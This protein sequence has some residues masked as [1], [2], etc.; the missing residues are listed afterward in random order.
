MRY[1]AIASL[2]LVSTFAAQAVRADDNDPYIRSGGYLGVGATYGV[3]FM[4]GTFKDAFSPLDGDVSNTWG[5]HATGGYRFGK[6]ISTEVE[7]EWMKAFNAR[8]S[9]IAVTALETQTATLNLKIHAPYK[10]F[11]PYFLVGAGATWVTQDKHFF[12]PLDVT[13]PSFSAR[14][15]AGLDYYFTPSF[16]LNLGTDMVVNSARVSVPGGKGRGLD[17]LAAQFGFGYRF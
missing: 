17:Y 7:Y 1:L 9:G 11:Q 10:E 13:S 14:F 6:W 5:A 3:S 4:D 16:Y 15:G 2:F 12:V 8:A